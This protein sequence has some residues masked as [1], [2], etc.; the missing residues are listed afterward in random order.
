MLLYRLT[1]KKYK[2]DLSGTGAAVMGGRWNSM[3]IKVLYTSSS[4]AL[5]MAEVLVHLDISE[6][7]VDAFYILT[8]EI[9]DT[10]SIIS[11]SVKDLSAN[12]NNLIDELPETKK[13]GDRFVKENKAC[14]LKVP[15]AV[16]KGDFNY[17]FNPQNKCFKKIK[18]VKEEPFPF[19]Q[20]LFIK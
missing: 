2:N 17:L 19:D 7:P 15:S 18:I 8:L 12:W 11:V 13:I 5:A 10:K 3:G 16:V 20:R 9:P 14:L 1:K 6:F 4:I